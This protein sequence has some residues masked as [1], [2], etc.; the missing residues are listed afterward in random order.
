[1]DL[2]SPQRQRRLMELV[3]VEEIWGI[4][5]RL[6]KRLHA[7]GVRTALDLADS[8][9]KL[10]RKQFSVV[11]ERTVRELNGESCI[12]LEEIPA[13]KKQI[14]CSRS[15]GQRVT[16]FNQMREAVCEHTVR[17]GEKLRKERQQAKVLTVFIRTSPFS[18]DRPQYS[19]AASSELV[20]ATDNTRD[21]IALAVKLL[22]QIWRDDYHYAKC[23]VMLSD[24]YAS[25]IYQPDIFDVLNTHPKGDNRS[26][27]LMTLMDQV[28]RKNKGGLFF[29]GLQGIKK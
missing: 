26:N 12:A 16:T 2:T 8:P 22:R 15:F 4:G 1:M 17:A 13:A 9:E 29:A 6:G 25:G 5:R 24:F 19:N 20:N 14:V 7:M 10:I 23:G 3:P 28:N 27:K 11:V 18:T 21:L